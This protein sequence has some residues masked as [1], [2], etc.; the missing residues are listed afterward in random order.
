[1][2]F[3]SLNQEQR[4][5][6]VIIKT[7]W[8]ILRNK[9][10]KKLLALVIFIVLLTIPI[11]S[12]ALEMYIGDI[13]LILHEETGS[14]SLYSTESLTSED[15]TSLLLEQD[16]G[17]SG[18]GLL[19]DNDLYNPG[20]SYKFQ[21]SI[22]KTP[23]GAKF[24]WNSNMVL[25]EERFSAVQSKYSQVADGIKIEIL[26][27]NTSE[28]VINVGLKFI[29][30]TWLGEK[31][32]NHFYL[33]DGTRVRSE[34]KLTKYMPTYWL[35]SE[36]AQDKTGLLV[37]L[38]GEGLTIPDE[39]VFANWKR[40]NSSMWKFKSV[41]KRN[42]NLQ[43]YSINDSAV[44][45]YYNPELL[46]PSETRQIVLLMGKPSKNG[47]TD[48]PISVSSNPLPSASPSAP[49]SVPPSAPPN[50][51]SNALSNVPSNATSS[52]TSNSYANKKEQITIKTMQLMEIA[53]NEI[54]L[55]ENYLNYIDE[56]LREDK[57]LSKE[58][59]NSLYLLIKELEK[60]LNDIDND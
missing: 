5:L 9:E 42:F 54:A 23:K 19:L 31:T 37:M 35:S 44:C 34:K 6:E 18:I 11:F 24:V 53:Q 38:N 47:F 40:I 20:M 13:K 3:C 32:N 59:M 33:S 52:T 30:D 28:R 29:L 57:V 48:S 12:Q 14:I 15:Y 26:I 17:T 16:P 36:D 55:S 2:N 51:P 56:L 27:K 46:K 43:P 41:S 49:P 58:E 7:I 50:V 25:V 4:K 45:H 1:M 60:I 39:V 21:Q 8:K 22:F 10:V